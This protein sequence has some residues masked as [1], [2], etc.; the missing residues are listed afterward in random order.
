MQLV[1]YATGDSRPH[2]EFSLDEEYRN[3]GVMTQELPKYLKLCRKWEYNQLVAIVEPNNLP[4]MKLLEAN[5][6]FRVY[7]EFEGGIPYICDIK[8]G[9][10]LKTFIDGYYGCAGKIE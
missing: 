1:S 4:S 6:F 3:Q 8:L 2:I 10:E 9:K 7:K 5:D